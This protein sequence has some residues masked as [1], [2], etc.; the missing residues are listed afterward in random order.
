MSKAI[1]KKSANH[2]RS[3]KGHSA[4][5]S[6]QLTI[7]LAGNPNSGKTTTF[8]SLT[9]AR[10]RV[11]NYPGV[12]VEKKEGDVYYKGYHIRVVDLPGTY[13]LTAYS[14]DEIIARN[15]ILEDKPQVVVNV[16]DASN[17]ERNLYLAVQFIEM[18]IP[19]IITLNMMDVAKSKGFKIDVEQLSRL[20]GVPIV[21]TV[22]STDQGVPELL[23]QVVELVEGGAGQRERRLDYGEEL[24]EEI[25]KLERVIT[26]DERLAQKLPVRW[27][28][29]KLLENDSHALKQVMKISRQPQVVMDT[30]S[31]S[32]KHLH[33]IFG[34]DPE[35]VLVDRRYGFVEGAYHESVQLNSQERTDISDTIDLLLTNR[36]LSLPIFFGLMWLVYNLAFTFS[37]APTQW[38]EKLFELLSNVLGQYLPAGFYRSL[39]LDGV[40][41]GVGN[42][43]V[44][45][46][47]ILLLFLAIAILEDSGYMA[48]V[49]FIMD[50]IMHRIGLHGKSVIP[51]IMG[52]GCGVPAIMATRTLASK[53][54]RIATMMIIPFMSCSAR[55]PVYALLIKAFFDSGAAANVLFSIYMLGIGMAVLMAKIFQ[56]VLFSDNTTPFIME[57][58]PYRIPTVKG[59]LIHMWQRSRLYFKKAGGIILLASVVL[60][61]LSNF[62]SGPKFAGNINPAS[63]TSQGIAQQEMLASRQLEN[64]IAG[65]IGRILTPILRPIGLGD[66]RVGVALF[67][68][69]VAKEVVISSMA[70]L[71]SLGE[72]GEEAVPLRVAIKKDPVFNPLSAYTLM[73]FVLLYL[74]CMSTVAVIRRETGGWGW[75]LFAILY[76]TVVAWIVSFVVY[77]GGLLLGLG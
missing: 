32:R 50:R 53:R 58:P 35:T 51:M 52:F 2:Q 20:L 28:A 26:K 74:P 71:Y 41:G 73:V 44:L 3:R 33:G 70:T 18:G 13:S 25:A 64:S 46:P 66:W 23:N 10:Q 61:F 12:T 34:D 27:L 67:S 22:A 37:E 21:P 57:L 19:F 55:L 62:P 9:G 36:I 76:T 43:L 65:R 15:F 5:K 56:R 59:L 77:N 49:A 47:P 8:N 6:R 4:A 16:V 39:L 11:A 75:P 31:A 68:G 7:A 48:R 72:V 42:V 63:E 40:L 45:L 14:L 1:S 30:A 54:D 60:W 38:L 17:L 29:I 24:E 69:F